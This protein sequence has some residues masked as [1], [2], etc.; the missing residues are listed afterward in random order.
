MK[1]KHE[2]LIELLEYDQYTGLFS[3]RISTG[4]CNRWGA[5]TSPG[6]LDNKGYLIISLDGVSYLA[7]RLAWFYV[8]GMWP[9]RE[10]DH[11]NNIKLDNRISNLRDVDRQVNQHNKLSLLKNNR[12]GL[13][14][15]SWSSHAKKW[16]SRIKLNGIEHYLGYFETKEEAYEAYVK[17]KSEKHPSVVFKQET[18]AS[19]VL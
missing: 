9:E 11:I 8:N 6:Y 2:R 13:T 5:G 4:R 10:I 1:I 18:N 17:A 7:H 12:T 16:R 19:G 14:G 3:R 15:V